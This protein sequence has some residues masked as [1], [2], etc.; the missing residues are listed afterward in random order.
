MTNHV[1][2]NDENDLQL[3]IQ[4]FYTHIVWCVYNFLYTYL[5]KASE[6]IFVKYILH[7]LMQMFWGHVSVYILRLFYK[8]LGL[9]PTLK[10]LFQCVFIEWKKITLAHFM[11][12]IYNYAYMIVNEY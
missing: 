5:H 12:Y 7:G 6:K 2:I 1:T 11:F 10:P 4:T 8:A 9:L 3:H